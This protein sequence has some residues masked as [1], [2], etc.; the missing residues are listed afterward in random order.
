[1]FSRRSVGHIYFVEKSRCHSE[2]RLSQNQDDY[3]KTL[4]LRMLITQKTST[5]SSIPEVIPPKAGLVDSW[6]AGPDVYSGSA[7]V[8]TNHSLLC[9]TA[10]YRSILEPDSV[11]VILTI[12]SLLDFVLLR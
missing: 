3:P 2:G 1:M 8:M 9:R 6:T 10:T 4:M 5:G 12:F 11:E 7:R